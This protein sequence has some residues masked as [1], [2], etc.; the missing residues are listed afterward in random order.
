M[1]LFRKNAVSSLIYAPSWEV[2]CDLFTTIKEL[3]L[4]IKHVDSFCKL[5]AD[6]PDC[7]LGFIYV[8]N[9]SFCCH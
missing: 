7:L 1:S 2:L 4:R 6:F 8:F 5:K 9:L 3:R